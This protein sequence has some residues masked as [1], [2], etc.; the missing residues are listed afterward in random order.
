MAQQKIQMEVGSNLPPLKNDIILEKKKELQEYQVL[1][2]IKLKMREEKRQQKFHEK[3]SKKKSRNE[4]N[5]I[6]SPLKMDNDTSMEPQPKDEIDDPKQSVQIKEIQIQKF[7]PEPEPLI[8]PAQAL[9]IRSLSEDRAFSKIFA[10]HKIC[11]EEKHENAKNTPTIN[12]F[13]HFDQGKMYKELFMPAK[14]PTEEL[15]CIE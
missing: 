12:V 11:S 13:R 1:K 7:C 8:A 10:T 6:M 4:S 5:Y 3:N 9:S 15:F 2:Q 14:K